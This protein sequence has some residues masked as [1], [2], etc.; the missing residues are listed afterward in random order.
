MIGDLQLGRSSIGVVRQSAP[1]ESWSR[2]VEQ[3]TSVVAA[4]H[5]AAP[6]HALAARQGR[7]LSRLFATGQVSMQ[8]VHA[9]N[10]PA[11]AQP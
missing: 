2:R 9:V 11:M 8:L 6:A 5:R 3:V 7:R 1:G 10:S 4:R